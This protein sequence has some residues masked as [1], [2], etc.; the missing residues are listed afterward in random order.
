[1]KY[2]KSTMDYR[3]NSIENTVFTEKTILYDIETTGL[4]RLHHQ[5]YLIGCCTRTGSEITVHQFFAESPE[6]EP[7]ILTAFLKLQEHYDTCITFNG[8]FF[9]EPF[10][11]ARLSKYKLPE[12]RL[13]TRHLDLYREA[14][15][16]KRPLRLSSLKQKD[17][18][19]FLG[20]RRE[21]VCTGGELIPVYKSY[22]KTHEE[23]AAH[24]LKLH[25]LEDVTGMVNLLP[26][27]SYLDLPNS[28]LIVKTISPEDTKDKDG[29]PGKELLI[30]GTLSLRLPSPL[31]LTNEYYY[32]LIRENTFRGSIR[33][34]SETLKHYL[35]DYKR[36][37]YLLEED[38]VIPKEL[39]AH[40]DK[41]AK[42]PATA[43]TCYI[44][45]DGLFLQ[46]PAQLEVS[47]EF[48]LFYRQ[49]KKSA[50]FLAYDK[51]AMDGAFF[52]RYLSAV[53]KESFS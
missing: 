33:L 21:D 9:D 31:R 47:R 41:T 37:V 42:K 53:I 48:P 45:K 18:E 36:Y 26:I 22:V 44:K 32:L 6:E 3:P 38:I 30:E 16:L 20:I 17:L 51:D 52:S 35:P 13:F 34:F 25:N 49:R 39:A 24:L 19:A 11:K 2:W 29:I 40:V 10:L 46:L 4:S 8:L 1:M 15:S 12:Y 27:L 5:I 43:D 23:Q 14:L 50:A 7:E 28:S